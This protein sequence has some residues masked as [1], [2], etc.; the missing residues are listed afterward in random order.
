[1][2]SGLSI[3]RRVPPQS[4]PKANQC[5]ASSPR[6]SAQKTIDN[7]PLPTSGRT[8]L[9]DH[10]AKGL[11][12]RITPSDRSWSY[13]FKSP[14]TGKN[15]RV[16][17]PN[18][19]LA[20][21]R[22][23]ARELRVAVAN[24]RDPGVKNKHNAIARQAA[25]SGVL[26]VAG[27]LNLYETAVVKTAARTVSRRARMISLRKTLEPFNDIAAAQ[28]KRGPIVL[29][30]DHEVQATRGPI[31]RNRA[32]SEIRHWLG[33]LHN[34]GLVETIELAL[35]VKEVKEIARE[36]VLTNPEL[37]AI[38]RSTADRSPFSD[39]VHVLMH[40]GMRRG[41]AANLQPRDLDFGAAT[42]RSQK[43]RSEQLGSRVSFR[44][45]RR[46]RECGNELK[47]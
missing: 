7:T 26:T 30:L 27:A 5:R 15:G 11:S 2:T 39:I 41:E 9:R 19:T 23:R 32:Q 17:L 14:L 44:W 12:L 34:R 33:W 1:M 21:A 3:Q 42:I 8:V 43:K 35:I 10:D 22:A 40:T 6:R 46:S 47:G 37:A 16:T 25:H 38:M 29:Q 31:A 4:A 36:R 24:G 20:E 13:E 28:L 45:T 18:M